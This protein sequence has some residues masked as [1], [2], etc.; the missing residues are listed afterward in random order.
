MP[1]ENLDKYKEAAEYLDTSV[2]KVAYWHHQSTGAEQ[3]IVFVHGFPSA[4]WDWHHQ[5][6]HCK[7][8]YNLVAMDMLGFGLSDKP[9]KHSYSLVE[10]A[11]LFKQLLNHLQVGECHIL[12]HDYGDSVAQHLLYLSETEQLGVKV[13]SICFL[14]G[15]L[16]SESHRPLFMQ[17]FLKSSLGPLLVPL[18][19]KRSLE[20]SFSKIFGKSTPPSSNDIDVI[21]QLLQYKQGSR[22]MPNLLGYI[23]ERKAWR[24]RWLSAMQNTAIPLKLINGRLDP[25]SGEHMTLRYR[26]LIPDPDVSLIEAGHY[27]QL[28]LPDTVSHLYLEFVEQCSTIL[29]RDM[30]LG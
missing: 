22:V 14:N 16:F 7:A 19:S 12:A 1:I 27:P 2:G 30:S 28:E 26:E 25:I 9:N 6:E 29:G 5:W 24:E 13:H 3:T 21:W 4:A 18:M 15:G 23:D 10:Q 8:N 11:E 17:K 20:K